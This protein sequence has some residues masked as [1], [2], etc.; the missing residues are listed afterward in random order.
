MKSPA[1]E[2]RIAWLGLGVAFAISATW[3]LLA[4]GVLTFHGDE[5][6]YYANLV[7]R[8]GVTSQVYGLEY[9]F[10]PHNGHLVLLG[11]L[12]YEALFAVAGTD[13]GVFRAVEVL[14][15]L[16]C[17]GLFFALAV[18][19]TS[20]LVAL[21]LSILLVFFGYANETLMW[22]FDLHTVYSAALGL[23]AI[24]A[25]ERD[26]RAGD[27]AGCVLLALSV[28][29]LEVGLAF[30]VG[31]AVLVLLQPD[32]RRRLW[33][34]LVPLALYAAWW[35]WARQFDQSDVLF[36]NIRLVPSELVN[37]L[38]AVVGCLLGL[39]PTGA[40]ARPEVV[41]I[42]PAATVAAGFALA[43]LVYRLRRG[44]VPPTLWAFLATAIAYWLTMAAG[45]RPPDS[46][47]YVFVG[48][49]LVLLV[50]VDALRGIRFG[51][52]ATA[53][54]FLVVALAIPANI[55][56]LYDG[57]GPEI[58]VSRVTGS[59]YAMLD[60]ARGQGVDPGFVP[61]HDPEVE[62]AGGGLFVPLA[63]GDYFDA[64]DRNG[65]L[66][67]SLGELRG[68]DPKYGAIADATLAGA[69]RLELAPGEAPA[70][71]ASCPAIAD[72]TATNI[73]YFELEPGGTVLGNRGEDTVSVGLSRFGPAA[74]GTP[75]GQ[76]EPGEWAEVRIPPDTAADPW[77]AVVN[78][79]VSVC[80]LP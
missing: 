57:R 46:T 12:V 6:F 74:P 39:N 62:A 79:P 40:E 35:L 66:G 2:K 71:S 54:F 1:G 56:K 11:R 80:P 10:A 69:L 18:R 50:A 20:P 53:G 37:A 41:G 21:A 13:Y 70:G 76:L 58:D 9:L 67:M 43:G 22:P 77:R 42:T 3:L 16:A 45:G 75:I 19:R 34:F 31:V 24:L 48:A 36:T 17:S 28:L 27:I 30:V 38:A 63:A 15:V 14:G 68:G 61:A 64:V 26:D 60:L 59:E 33:I 7:T 4:G 72:A 23:G 44:S 8:E 47:R 29:M 51:R 32:R 49:V 73:A 65:S 52:L 25:L 5:I 78:G 55:A